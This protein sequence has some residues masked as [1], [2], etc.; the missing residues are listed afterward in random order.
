MNKIIKGVVTAGILV[1][2]LVTAA[3]ATNGQMQKSVTYADYKITVDG[4]EVTPTDVNGKST[5]P[6]AIEGSIYVPIR[7]ISEALGCAVDYQDG[8]V[9]I[10]TDGYTGVSG[11]PEAMDVIATIHNDGDATKLTGEAYDQYFAGD[12]QKGVNALLNA[13]AVCINGISVPAN[14]SENTDYQI[15]GVSS[16]YKTDT[17]WGYN[18]HK[19]TSANNLTFEDAR[20]Q[21]VETASTV[22]GHDTILYGDAST[23]R[24]NKVDIQSYE[25]FRIAYF[26]DHG[27]QVDKIQRGEFDL[28]T[29]RVRMDVETITAVNSG[30]GNFDKNIQIGDVV[31]YW[32]STDGWHMVKA[33]PKTGVISK[34]EDGEFVCTS[35]DDVYTMIES[36][37]S[38][39]NLIDC[40][41]PTQFY[42]NTYVRMGINDREVVLWCTPNG[43]PIGFTLGLDKDTSKA[44]LTAVIDFAKAAKENVAVSVD[45]TD[46]A[47]GAMWV[48]Q[49]DMDAFDA[50]IAEA[51]AVCNDNSTELYKY[52]WA[53]YQLAVAYGDSGNNPSGFVGAQGEGSK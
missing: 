33:T 4:Q 1:G 46:V 6:F 40:N 48:T 13:G 47:A 11:D 19:T 17:G 36:N 26:E 3:L 2:L 21:F 28:E 23:G 7:A 51:E 20:L 52:D 29:A 9:V 35:G 30:N 34:T 5:E 16:L 42:N 24:V 32:Y 27:G 41:R 53:A 25:V 14:D 39:Y 22:R 10:T 15:N 8:T 31:C 37:V 50:A 43:Y 45:G 12:A 18:V 38:R 44:N 49:A